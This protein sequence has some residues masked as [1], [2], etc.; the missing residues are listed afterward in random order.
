MPGMVHIDDNFLIHVGEC[1]GNQLKKLK[2]IPGPMSKIMPVDCDVEPE[3]KGDYTIDD[4]TEIK[5]KP[6]PKSKKHHIS[7][8][9]T[10]VKKEQNQLDMVSKC[11]NNSV[12]GSF[13]QILLNKFM[14]HMKGPRVRL[15]RLIKCQTCDFV[16]ESVK[17]MA[18]HML[19]KHVDY[20]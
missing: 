12:S 18:P 4:T 11:E 19:S 6:G 8:P 5:M 9:S 10:I 17:E 13:E 14:A 7:F 3:L 2:R 15:N 1:N 20:I 16:A